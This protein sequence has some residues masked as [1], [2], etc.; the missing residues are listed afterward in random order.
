M[1]NTCQIRS[2]EHTCKAGQNEIERFFFVYLG[3][4]A[5]YKYN[6]GQRL[7]LPHLFQVPRN[8]ISFL[9]SVTFKLLSASREEK[10]GGFHVGPGPKINAA[11]CV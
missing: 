8:R 3:L 11:L 6:I 10:F 2:G 4:G 7:V 9:T 1:T 5:C